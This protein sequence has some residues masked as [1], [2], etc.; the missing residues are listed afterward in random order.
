MRPAFLSLLLVFV[1]SIA[2][3][4]PLTLGVVLDQNEA[5]ANTETDQR[6]RNFASEIGKALDQPV[7]LQYFKRGF[8]AIKQAK[9]G[10]L[11]IVFGPAHVIA[12]ISKFKFEPILKS[13]EMTAAAFVAAPSYRGNLAAKSGARLGVP[14]YESLMGGMARSEINSRGLAKSDFA[15]IKFH[16]MAEAPLYGLKLGRFGRLKIYGLS[17]DVWRDFGVRG[18]G[19]P[20]DAEPAAAAQRRNRRPAAGI[21]LR[22]RADCALSRRP[23]PGQVRA[24]RGQGRNRNSTAGQHRGWRA[25][26]LPGRRRADRLC[27]TSILPA[28]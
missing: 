17:G 9:E 20:R 14:D 18:A 10:T 21:L 8:T 22:A 6:Y 11:D 19:V 26:L 24:D 16:R 2:Q 13:N 4:A 15:E 7:R 3:A 23:D 5:F 25:L 1:S 28:Q 27:R 12:N